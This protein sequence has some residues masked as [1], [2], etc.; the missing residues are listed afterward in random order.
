MKYIFLNGIIFKIATIKV[1]IL[2]LNFMGITLGFV[3]FL[4]Q[5][6]VFP[7]MLRLS[8]ECTFSLSNLLE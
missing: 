7:G 2:L 5:T 4:K 8:S 6:N 1:S 3:C